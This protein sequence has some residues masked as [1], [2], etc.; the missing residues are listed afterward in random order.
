M[1]AKFAF[2]LATLLACVQLVSADFDL[3]Q[4]TGAVDNSRYGGWGL[5]ESSGNC[6]SISATWYDRNDLSH[7]R[8]GVRCVGDCS[9]SDVSSQSQS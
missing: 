8:R 4:V 3:Y 5:Y 2:I 7:Q 1:S 9:L 6:D